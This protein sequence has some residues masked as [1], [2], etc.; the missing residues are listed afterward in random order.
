MV[1]KPPSLEQRGGTPRSQIRGA[2]ARSRNMTIRQQIPHLLAAAALSMFVLSPSVA[3]AGHG[4]GGGGVGGHGGGHEHFGGFGGGHG[5]GHG[6]ASIHGHGHGNGHGHAGGNS[7]AHMSATGRA[8]TNGPNATHRVFGQDRAAL[9]HQMHA[10]GTN[11]HAGAHGNGHGN[12]GGNSAAHMSAQGLANTN[13]PNA[14][15]RT[16]GKDRAELRHQVHQP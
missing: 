1:G 11:G 4:D 6:H 15:N 2:S 16:H 3:L 8:N 7:A 5:G 14:T 13:G 10:N 12:A 9:R